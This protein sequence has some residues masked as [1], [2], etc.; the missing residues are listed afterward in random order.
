MKSEELKKI[1]APIKAKYRDQPEGAIVT[2][3]ARGK[4]G[5]GISCKVETGKKLVEADFILLPEE[6]VC[7]S[8][9]GICFSKLWL[10]VQA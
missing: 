1:Q 9:P 4:I 7:L 3:K 10:V 8:V 6:R 2:L 5:E